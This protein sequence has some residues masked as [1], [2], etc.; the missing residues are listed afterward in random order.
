MKNSVKICI[1][2]EIGSGKTTLG[3]KIK[4]ALGYDYVSIGEILKNYCTNKKIFPNRENLD[5]LSS[6]IIKKYGEDKKFFWLIKNSPEVNWLKP[7]VLDGFRN[8]KVYLQCKKKFPKI[9]LIYCCCPYKIQ[10]NR[11]I[12]RDK[13]KK[14][15]VTKIISQK[16]EIVSKKLKKHADIIFTPEKKSEEIIKEIKELI[17]KLSKK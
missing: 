1:G 11:I 6:F 12:K 2:G 13:I 14:N 9:I 3:K 16:T 17:K 8:E 4:L 10:I 7:L 5:K 15:E